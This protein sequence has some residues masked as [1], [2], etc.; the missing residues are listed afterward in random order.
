MTI[1]PPTPFRALKGWR[2]SHRLVCTAWIGRKVAH[3]NVSNIKLV[4]IQDIK[5][6]LALIYFPTTRTDIQVCIR[7]KSDKAPAISRVHQSEA[8]S[9]LGIS[10]PCEQ[11]H[12]HLCPLPRCTALCPIQEFYRHFRHPLCLR[13]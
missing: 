13:E 1:R 12:P 11:T 2:F 8:H 9:L 5:T 4:G 6:V 10:S 3:E 7:R